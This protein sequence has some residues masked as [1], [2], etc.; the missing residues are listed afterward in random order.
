MANK[1]IEPLLVIMTIGS[2]LGLF[3]ALYLMIQTIVY[4]YKL[5]KLEKAEK[6][7]CRKKEDKF[8]NR[9]LTD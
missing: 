2:F 4:D 6:D 5:W 9:K 7:R 1:L 8:K 3:L